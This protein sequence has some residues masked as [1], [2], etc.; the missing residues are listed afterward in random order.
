MHAQM[1]E[2]HTGI[3]IWFWI[4]CHLTYCEQV[5]VLVSILYSRTKNRVMNGNAPL[6]IFLSIPISMTK[7]NGCY[8][9]EKW[10]KK[11]TFQVFILFDIVKKQNIN[12]S[13][14]C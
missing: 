12:S 9:F 4:R 14:S 13:Y 7:R 6:R 8:L 11:I 3:T 2:N 1:G 5:S 10:L